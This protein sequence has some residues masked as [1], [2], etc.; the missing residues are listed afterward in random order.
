MPSTMMVLRRM[1]KQWPVVSDQWPVEVGIADEM[2][3]WQSA[4]H[5]PLTT[6]HESLCLFL[7]ARGCVRGAPVLLKL[8]MQGFQPDS[9]NFRS[10]RLVIAG[11][12]QSFEDEHLFRLSHGRAH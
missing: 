3:R 12:L 4:F 2:M 6:R 11:G 5:R 9:E 8:I 1:G 10:L 7:L